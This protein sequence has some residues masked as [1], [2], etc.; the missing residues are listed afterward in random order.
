MAKRSRNKRQPQCPDSCGIRQDRWVRSEL[1]PDGK[2]KVKCGRCGRFIGYWSPN[3]ERK[4]ANRR[5]DKREKST[6]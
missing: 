2:A 6:G 4:R 3:Q 5:I 1:G